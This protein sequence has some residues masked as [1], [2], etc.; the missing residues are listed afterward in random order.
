MAA[1]QGAD[2]AFHTTI[3]VRPVDA[4]SAE[5]GVEAVMGPHRHEPG[6]FEPF[7]PGAIRITAGFKLSSR[8]IPVG[9]PPKASKARTWPSR[10]DSWFGWRR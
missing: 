8:I 7:R 4:E 10:K 3:H 1:P 9:T 6:M 5:E 2:L